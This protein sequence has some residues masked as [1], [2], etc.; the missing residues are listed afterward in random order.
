MSDIFGICARN[1]LYL[2]ADDYKMLNILNPSWIKVMSNMDLSVFKYLSG[3]Y[4]VITRLYHPGFNSSS[5]VEAE[6]FSDWAIARILQI[7]NY[8]RYYQILNEPNHFAGFE[9]GNK[10]A[11]QF[12]DWF[13]AVYNNLKNEY[14]DLSFLFP[15]LAIPHR[16]LEWLDKCK[17]AVEISDGLGC[18]CYWQ[19]PEP[20]DKNHLSDFW[21]LR[22]KKYHDK[23]PGKKIYI[24]EAANSNSQ[25]GFQFNDWKYAN[26]F[27]EW[28]NEVKKYNY[29]KSVNPF[30]MSSPD[31]EWGA[32]SWRE[33]EHM[34]EV[35]YR[36][37][38]G[39]RVKRGQA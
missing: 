33:N 21:G 7:K 25:S 16:D 1:D 35:V 31:K 8:S 3:K 17:L 23:F 38:Y 4:N 13:I 20:E 26:E 15:G 29:I 28:Y 36:M 5:I 12:N 34:K 11:Q 22:F 2:K 27:E 6:E 30:I 14:P 10:S 19:N 32:F 37:S 18:H 24:L 9:F 39:N